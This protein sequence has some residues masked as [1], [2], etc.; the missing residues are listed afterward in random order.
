MPIVL[1]FAINWCL[2]WAIYRGT[3]VIPLWGLESVASDMLGTS[4]VLPW[5]NCVI[6]SAALKRHARLGRVP[7]L[8]VDGTWWPWRLVP[9]S[10]VK[11]GLVLAVLCLVFVALPTLGI[12]DV[13]GL[14]QFELRT[15]LALNASYG[16]LL[17][18]LASPVIAVSVLAQVSREG[19]VEGPR[20]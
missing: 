17:A 2:A 3:A 13:L 7:R 8:G 20:T 11:R 4:L 10:A 5:V 12:L 9:R 18:A 15:C 1:N 14:K 19:V 6:N 16:A